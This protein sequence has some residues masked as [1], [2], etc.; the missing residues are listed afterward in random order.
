M[1]KKFTFGTPTETEAVICREGIVEPGE[2][3]PYFSVASSGGDQDKSHVL[4]YGMGEQDIVYG[5]GENIRGINKRGWL[6]ESNCT[7]DPK[8]TESK[9]SLY[10]AHNFFLVDGKERFGVFVDAPQKT[11]FEISDRESGTEDRKSVV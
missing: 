4:T 7:D 8:H 5:L 2:K 1:I 11:V 6:Y 10:A 9:H 3:V